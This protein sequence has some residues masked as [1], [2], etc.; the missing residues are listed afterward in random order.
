MTFIKWE[1]LL[2]LHLRHRPA[3][4]RG[5]VLPAEPDVGVGGVPDLRGLGARLLP[6]AHRGAVRRVRAVL[7]GR[8]PRQHPH[9]RRGVLV[10]RVQQQGEES[11]QGQEQE[12]DAANCLTAFP[13]YKTQLILGYVILSNYAL[14][15]HNCRLL[16]NDY[17]DCHT[18]DM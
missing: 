12:H 8:P 14:T 9:R 11:E 15:L 4:L 18:C 16:I 1:A 2:Q 13:H 10:R 5:H 7:A 6:A 3:G 17:R